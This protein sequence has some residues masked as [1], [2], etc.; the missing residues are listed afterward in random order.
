MADYSETEATE[1]DLRV[2]PA[3]ESHEY[4]Y[5]ETVD[6]PDDECPPT[7]RGDAS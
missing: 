1:P 5:D 3:A 2:P 4:A 7:L 6:D